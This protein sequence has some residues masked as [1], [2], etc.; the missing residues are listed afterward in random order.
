MSSVLIR[1]IRAT[2]SYLDLLPLIRQALQKSHLSPHGRTQTAYL[3]SNNTLHIGTKFNDWWVVNLLSAG[4]IACRRWAERLELT[5]AGVADTRIFKCYSPLFDIY[6]NTIPTFVPF[7]DLPLLKER[8]R[9]RLS[10][11]YKGWSSTHGHSVRLRFS[12]HFSPC[13]RTEC[14]E[15]EVYRFWSTWCCSFRGEIG[16]K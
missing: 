4:L 8:F 13:W 6:L 12:R 15:R 9:F 2:L 11:N 10:R 5:G 16:G 14:K 7:L 1:L 3:V